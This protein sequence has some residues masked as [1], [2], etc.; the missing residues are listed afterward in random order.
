M[1][2]IVE[3]E[4]DYNNLDYLG[5]YGPYRS[6]KKAKQAYD[7][8]MLNKKSYVSYQIKKIEK[9]KFSA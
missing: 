7:K 9:L 3:M 1:F 2:V 6:D 4:W 5:V 8:L